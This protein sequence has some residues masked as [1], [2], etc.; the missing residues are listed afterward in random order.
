MAPVMVV[1][2]CVAAFSSDGGQPRNRSR[3]VGPVPDAEKS[4]SAPGNLHIAEVPQ[5]ILLTNDDA[6]TPSLHRLLRDVV[7]RRK[8]NGCSISIT[9]F[10][11]INNPK[12][13]D[14]YTGADRGGRLCVIMITFDLM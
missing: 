5:F 4:L 2:F 10:A 3:D 8:A 14:D 12:Y 9:A 13:K 7:D 6:I 1:T 11:H